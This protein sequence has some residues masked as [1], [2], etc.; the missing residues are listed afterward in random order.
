[1]QNFVKNFLIVYGTKS[2][3][4]EYRSRKFPRLFLRWKAEKHGFR[5]T[6]IC[7]EKKLLI[8]VSWKSDGLWGVLGCTPQ[9]CKISDVSV[10]NSRLS[11]SLV[12]NCINFLFQNFWFLIFFGKNTHCRKKFTGPILCSFGSSIAAYFFLAKIPY[13][14]YQLNVQSSNLTKKETEDTSKR[15]SSYCTGALN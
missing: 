12:L 7:I 1:M 15:L 3:R 10:T 14:N 2:R 4:A 5:L 6:L 13:L 9:E 11:A 8:R